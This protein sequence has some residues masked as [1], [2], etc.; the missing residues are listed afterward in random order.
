MPTYSHSRLSTYENCPL[1]FKFN[2]IDRIKRETEGVEAFLGNRIHE[3]LRKCYEDIRR[4]KLDTLDELLTYY[5]SLWLKNWH[6]DIVINRKELNSEHYRN[7]G[8]KMLETYYRR[9]TPF[10]SDITIGTEL[11]LNFSLDE[12]KKYR[13]TGLVDRLARTPDNIFWIHDYKTSA[14]LPSQEEADRDRQLAL[15]HI[16]VKKRWPDIEDIRL[17]WHY[18]AF[19]CELV[20][21]RT[22][23]ALSELIDNTTQLIDNIEADG[24]FV[25]K[26]SPLCDWCEYPDLCPLRKHLY[27]VEN[28]PPNQYLTEPG[29]ELVNKYV[30]LKKKAGDIDRDIEQVREALI[31]YAQR[32]N[33]RVVTGSDHRARIKFDTKLKFPGKN[34]PERDALDNF[35]IQS[36]KWADVSQLDTNLLTRIVEHENWDKELI[37]RVMRYGRLEPTTSV[38]ISKI[39]ETEE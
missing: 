20:S 23:D 14:H 28:L 34:D 4:T 15:Y 10:D 25:P 35:I 11:M 5:E 21:T 3:T 6:D 36:G 29:V 1:Q 7:L 37:D 9:H 33:V 17:V 24:E 18:L 27:I 39:K 8:R 12:R 26:E 2:Y 13:L 38:S 16:G 31:D 22:D 30:E 19:D 32:E